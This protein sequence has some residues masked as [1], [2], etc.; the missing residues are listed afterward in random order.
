MSAATA[1]RQRLIRAREIQHMMAAAASAAAE[2]KEQHL[3]GIATRIAGLR[4]GL[5]ANTGYN[6]ATDLVVMGELATRLEG[7]QKSLVPHQQAARQSTEMAR[8]KTI[9]AAL[10][11]RRITRL[12]EKRSAEEE[13]QRDLRQMAAPRRMVAR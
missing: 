13:R 3:Q 11:E 5:S 8:A 12:D 4:Q 2:Q 7:A 6:R 10:A 9:H 1:R